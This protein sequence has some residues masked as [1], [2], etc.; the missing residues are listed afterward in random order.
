MKDYAKFY[1]QYQCIETDSQIKDK[2]KIGLIVAAMA[3]IMGA[4]FNIYIFKQEKYSIIGFKKWDKETVT[5]A[6]FAVLMTIR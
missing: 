4:V 2:R 1:V 3:M 6:D 5:V